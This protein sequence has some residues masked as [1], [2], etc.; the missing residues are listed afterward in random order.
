MAL[1]MSF[2]IGINTLAPT[3]IFFLYKH[4]AGNYKENP[5]LTYTWVTLALGVGRARMR[6]GEEV[7]W[8]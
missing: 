5:A 4:L 1:Q 3:L 2:I 8:C 6:S 7:V